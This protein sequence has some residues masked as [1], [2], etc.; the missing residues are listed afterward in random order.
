MVMALVFLIVLGVLLFLLAKE[1][2]LLIGAILELVALLVK[3]AVGLIT[4]VVIGVRE[5]Y[6]CV[7]GRRVVI[8]RRPQRPMPAKVLL[9]DRGD[10]V[11]VPSKGEW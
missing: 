9:V 1:T 6:R 7:Q 11:Y 5:V 3:L 10:G 2:V 8:D 4:L